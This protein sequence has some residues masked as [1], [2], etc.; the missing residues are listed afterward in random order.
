MFKLIVISTLGLGID[1]FFSKIQTRRS[2]NKTE[3]KKS[4]KEKKSTEERKERKRKSSEKENEKRENKRMKI[5]DEISSSLSA[6]TSANSGTTEKVLNHSKTSGENQH[7]EEPKRKQPI[8]IMLEKKNLDG[9][10]LPGTSNSVN[11]ENSIKPSEKSLEPS[12]WRSNEIILTEPDSD[13]SH[14]FYKSDDNENTANYENSDQECE[15]RTNGKASSLSNMSGR[16]GIFQE[17]NFQ[18]LPEC[19]PNS[20]NN[21]A[22]KSSLTFEMSSTRPNIPGI[23]KKSTQGSVSKP[24]TLSNPV[25]GVSKVSSWLTNEMVRSYFY[26]Y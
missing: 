18:S 26:I 17:D 11:P 15:T 21:P 10:I 22:K 9:N 23:L 7:S 13:E 5:N 1:D 2:N 16:V 12:M 8:N 3:K 6:K 19:S 14:G 4:S 24:E 20:S 25:P